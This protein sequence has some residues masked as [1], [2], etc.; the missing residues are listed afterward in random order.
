[1]RSDLASLAKLAARA[2]DA[3]RDEI[4]PRFRHVCV[5]I[6]G[7][8]SP[9]TEADRAA[10]QAI[11]RVL[12]EGDPGAAIVGEEFGAEGDVAGGA[13]WV[14]DPI[15]GT[16]GFSR[17]LPLFSTIIARLEGGVPVLG[18]IDLP[19]VGE[20]T[21]GWKGGGVTRNGVPVRCSQR[22]DLSDALIAH[23]DLFC[24][25]LA[26]ERPVFEKM[27]REIRILRGYTD[28][29]GHAQVLAGGIDAMV[30]LH[31]N[32]WDAAATQILVPEAGGRC[33]TLAYPQPGKLGLVFGAPALVDR[34]A[35]WLERGRPI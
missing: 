3:A 21:V 8:G 31:L 5:E 29:F 9:V 17:G 24:F 34:L 12:Q 15:D 6:K 28:A 33:I 25:D 35:G 18:L 19:G 4:L 30:D 27:A 32:P 23:G 1:M 11:R 14:I 13:A 16:I 10:E 26:G 20:R 7:D 2:A 22:T